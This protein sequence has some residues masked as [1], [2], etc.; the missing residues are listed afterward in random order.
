MTLIIPWW[1]AERYGI[2]WQRSISASAWWTTVSGVACL[3]FGLV[4]FLSCLR[5]FYVE[6]EGT[7]AP[8]DPPR[9]LVI[10]GPHA[11]VRNPMISGILFVLLGEAIVLRSP[12]HFAWCAVFFSINAAY[13]MLIEEPMLRARFG[14]D[15]DEYSRHVPRVV[16]RRTPWR[17]R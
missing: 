14:E 6:G 15:Y 7:L 2:D 16:P 1:I 9:R 12:A 5:R 10:E 11:Y 3:A 4:L 13:T 8:W 17:R